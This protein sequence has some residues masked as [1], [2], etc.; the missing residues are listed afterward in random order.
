MLF[1][2]LFFIYCTI[3]ISEPVD[4]ANGYASE[5]ILWRD[6]SKKLALNALLNIE[7]TEEAANR[8]ISYYGIN[9]LEKKNGKY[10]WTK[11]VIMLWDGDSTYRVSPIDTTYAYIRPYFWSPDGKYLI[12]KRGLEYYSKV[13]FY[14]W[15]IIDIIEKEAVDIIPYIKYNRIIHG[16]SVPYWKENEPNTMIWINNY[17]ADS[18]M[19]ERKYHRPDWYDV[20]MKEAMAN[21]FTAEVPVESIK[22][23]GH[24]FIKIIDWIQRE[25][26]GME[27]VAELWA[28]PEGEEPYLVINREIF[29]GGVSFSPNNDYVLVLGKDKNLYLISKDGSDL[30]KVTA[31]VREDYRFRGTWWAPDSKKFVY[32]VS[33]KEYP[34]ESGVYLVEILE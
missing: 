22:E 21:R 10:L 19:Y 28:N 12:S 32:S 16:D 25:G 13:S 15:A 18:I 17:I 2:F 33:S 24:F 9:D 4:I 6:G 23:P 26:G 1:N 11:S 27:R 14:D 30:T 29:G 34:E 3:N 8:L 31:S 7:L 20:F 5:F